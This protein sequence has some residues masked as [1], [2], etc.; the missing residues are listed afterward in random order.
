MCTDLLKSRFWTR[1]A[2]LIMKRVWRWLGL[3]M[4]TYSNATFC[5]STIFKKFDDNFG[6]WNRG[7]NTLFG[8]RRDEIGS[9][10]DGNVY[11]GNFFTSLINVRISVK[12]KP[13]SSAKRTN[14]FSFGVPV[15]I[16]FIFNNERRSSF[17]SNEWPLTSR[18]VVVESS[19]AFRWF[20]ENCPLKQIK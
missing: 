4:S 8:R 16:F 7:F 20:E 10:N 13:K 2:P 18:S 5:V 3:V 19:G 11:V 6:C 9:L 14:F 17:F 1:T 12:F 15:G